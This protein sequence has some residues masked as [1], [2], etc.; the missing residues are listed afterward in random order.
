[1]KVFDIPAEKDIL[2]AARTFTQAMDNHRVFALYG[3]MGAGKTTLVKAICQVLEVDDT[4]SSPTFALV[5]EYTSPVA[6]LIY[7]FDLY[8]IRSIE[9]LYDLGYE[10]YFF[11]GNLCFIE[12]PEKAEN[13]L[14]G[15][16]VNVYIEVNPDGT[17]TVKMDV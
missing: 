17:R 6:G 12:W 5:Y 9:E 15:D 11:G 14:P 10:D 16:V 7:H 1:M 3:E 8:R 13:L 2:Q 4:V